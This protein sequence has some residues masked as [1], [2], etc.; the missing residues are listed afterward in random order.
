MAAVRE[1]AIDDIEARLR[2]CEPRTLSRV[3]TRIESGDP[4]AQT[5][6]ERIYRSSGA[7][8]IVGV[9]G[10]PGAGKSTLLARLAQALRRA[11]SK[12]ALL[13]VDP[14]SPLT[15]GAI[16]GDRVRMSALTADPGI[17][18]RS[19]ATRG[20]A[21]GLARATFDAVDVLDA[22]GFGLVLVET[23]GVGQSE[24][25]IA[26]AADTTVL[27]SAPGLGDDVQAIKAGILEMADI[28]VVNK[29]DRPDAQ[30]TFLDIQSTLAISPSRRRA[31]VPVLLTSAESGQGIDGLAAAIADHL[32]ELDASGEGERR[33]RQRA[34]LRI[35]RAAETF[36][37]NRIRAGLRDAGEELIDAVQRH[38]CTPAQAALALLQRLDVLDG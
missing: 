21:G 38:E 22:A 32:A 11:H 12:I 13:M 9:T 25:E 24:L 29:A 33:R 27:V 10:V 4:E 34:E 2:A 1:S 17:F 20:A 19:M 23:V 30:R 5:L 6:L 16:L 8:R 35:R 18:I 37:A 31:R 14:S 26:H 7:A 3:L 36:V 15:G 28:Q